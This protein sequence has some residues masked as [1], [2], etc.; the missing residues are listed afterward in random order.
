M[1]KKKKKKK[2]KKAERKRDEFDWTITDFHP[3]II[4]TIL[5]IRSL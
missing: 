3:L 5:H 1:K 4:K 2:K